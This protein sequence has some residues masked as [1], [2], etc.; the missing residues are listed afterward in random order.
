M[1]K[2][3]QTWSYIESGPSRNAHFQK[4]NKI[5][6]R[7]LKTG[8]NRICTERKWAFSIHFFAK[9][10]GLTFLRNWRLNHS[11]PTP[12]NNSISSSALMCITTL[13]RACLM[14][15]NFNVQWCHPGADKN[16]MNTRLDT[17]HGPIDPHTHTLNQNW[18]WDVVNMPTLNV[19]TS[20]AAAEATSPI[21]Q[22]SS[23]NASTSF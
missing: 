10:S 14:G 23:L 5:G 17:V 7:E 12:L 16:Q 22:I 1:I 13:Y 20:S 2:H 6:I 19:T 9:R 15:Q 3:D 4:W 18:L 8:V 21:A 11:T